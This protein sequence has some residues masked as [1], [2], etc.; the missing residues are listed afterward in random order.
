MRF[1]CVLMCFEVFLMCFDV[2]WCVLICFDVFL[3]V[4]MCFYR[5]WLIKFSSNLSKFVDL[6]LRSKII[7]FQTFGRFNFFP[8]IRNF[9]ARFSQTTKSDERVRQN[10]RL[11]PILS[12]SLSLSLSLT[13][14]RSHSLPLSHSLTLSLSHALTLSLSRSHFITLSRSHSLTLSLSHF[15]THTHTH[16]HTHIHFPSKT[17]RLE[18][19]RICWESFLCWSPWVLSL[20]R[21]SSRNS[22]FWRSNA[23][24]ISS[25]RTE[26]WEI[27]EGFSAFEEI[28]GDADED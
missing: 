3:C 23:K 16:T 1:W 18:S 8:Q 24:E 6:L 13:P 19:W 5:F 7:R 4:F 22:C 25:G 11:F 12:R 28:F 2:F 17:N 15:H 26:F 10:K 27:F 14:W 20:W 9:F 21:I